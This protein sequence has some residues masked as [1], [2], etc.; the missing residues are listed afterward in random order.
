MK[1]KSLLRLCLASW[2]AIAFAGCNKDS[3]DRKLTQTVT[4]ISTNLP[5]GWRLAEADSRRLGMAMPPEWRAIDLTAGDFS[6]YVKKAGDEE[7]ALKPLL[8]QTRAMARNDQFKMFI[9]RKPDPKVAFGPN[10][11]LIAMRL[12][13]GMTLAEGVEQN[14]QQMKT[15]KATI[16]KSVPYECPA[17]RG[18]LLDWHLTMNAMKLHDL[19][20]FFISG[21]RFLILTWSL[22][23]DGFEKLKPEVEQM[24]ATFRCD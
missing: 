3:P 18:H 20:Y 8:E 23:E 16:D 14:I 13:K 19:T 6:E 17:G 21:E 4:K 1:A 9:V 15:L 10:M 7:P 2:L 5:A 12:P 22:P 24:M 11:N